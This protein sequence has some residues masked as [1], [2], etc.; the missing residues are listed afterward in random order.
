ML[1]L[2]R[3]S[4]K[5]RA[6]QIY[7]PAF[8]DPNSPVPNEP[9]EPTEPKPWK[10]LR[11]QNGNLPVYTRYSHAGAEVS[12]LVKHV[13]GDIAA[14]RKELMMVTEAPCRVRPGKLEVRGL[15]RWKLKEWLMSLG[16]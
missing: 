16:M 11:T 7:A 9:L 13:Y 3:Q 14:M 4:A 1:R 12:T 5:A 10:V 6:P 2:G 8:L 15:H